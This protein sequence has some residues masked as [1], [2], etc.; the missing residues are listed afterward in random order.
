[1]RQ[2][3]LCRA[4][5]HN[6]P[7]WGHIGQICIDVAD[8]N[9]PWSFFKVDHRAAYKNLSL[10]P[11]QADACIV[12]LRNPAGGLWYGFHP[13][14]LL[15]GSVA[16]VLRYNCFSRIVA[17]LANLLLGLPTVNYFDDLG[18]QTPTSIPEAELAA[19]TDF[20]HILGIILKDDK[21]EL[22]RLISFLGLEGHLPGPDNDMTLSVDLTDE[23]KRNWAGKLEEFL[24]R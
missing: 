12:T 5:E 17:I 22:G 9:R 20:G 16:A 10:N 3:G 18:S 23:K 8:S 21:T 6:P 1:M 19:L 13:R 7:T 14:A 4:D 11:D 24:A 15:F 2:L